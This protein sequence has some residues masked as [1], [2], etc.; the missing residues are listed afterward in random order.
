MNGNNKMTG[1]ARYHAQQFLND[2]MDINKESHLMVALHLIRGYYPDYK[3]YSHACIACRINYV[4][5]ETW[6][7]HRSNSQ[8]IHPPPS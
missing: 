3:H 4:T 1:L 6:D 2:P 8:T 5:P 7:Y